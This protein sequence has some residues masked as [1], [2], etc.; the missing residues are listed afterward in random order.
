MFKANLPGCRGGS[1][2]R[3]LS[4]LPEDLSPIPSIHFRRPQLWG[5]QYLWRLHSHAHTTYEHT[6]THPQTKTSFTHG[7]IEP[8]NTSSVDLK[9]HL[10]QGKGLGLF[11]IQCPVSG[12]QHKA[13]NTGHV[14][15]WLS[16]P[17]V[18]EETL[19]AGGS[20]GGGPGSCVLSQLCVAMH[21]G[22]HT[23]I[24]V[25]NKKSE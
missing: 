13:D 25:L 8:V 6:P 1:A 19:P 18:T 9:A 21:H 23:D 10:H 11:C 24:L 3:T 14:A 17:S 16:E 22:N 12:S 15:F 7:G 2:V 5:T 4:A 20:R